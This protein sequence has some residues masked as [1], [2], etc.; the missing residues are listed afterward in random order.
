M[1]APPV[2]PDADLLV[3]AAYRLAV[4]ITASEERAVETLESVP[5]RPSQSPVDYLNALRRQALDRRP[6]IPPETET[7][8]LPQGLETLSLSDWAVVERV[9]LRGM[10]L[11]QVAEVLELDR[12]EALL[13]LNRGMHVARTALV[14]GKRGD[15]ADSAGLDRLGDDLAASRLDDAPRDRQAEPAA[16]RG[17]AA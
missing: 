11:T 9:A 1:T 8:E 7:S 10:S 2:Q 16:A 6:P 17:A 3:T 15:D 14:G 4:R 13:R 12:G 5:F